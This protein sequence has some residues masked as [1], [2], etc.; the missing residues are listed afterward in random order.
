MTSAAFYIVDQCL[1]IPNILISILATNPTYILHTM[2]EDIQER[3]RA[4]IA[5]HGSALVTLVALRQ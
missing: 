4:L 2:F 3:M 1:M 5:Q